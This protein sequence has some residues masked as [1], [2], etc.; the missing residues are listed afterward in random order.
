MSFCGALLAAALLIAPARP[1]SAQFGSS[2]SSVTSADIQRL[3]DAIY[4]ASRDVSQLRSRDQALASDLQAQLDDLRED[5]IY[6]KV[7]QRRSE[8]VSRSEV[9]D[10][11]D[12]IESI[13]ARARGESTGYS[14]SF[15]SST[16]D[17]SR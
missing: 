5:V 17:R 1:A 8:M 16:T 4:D 10:V 3:Q 12:R 6:L 13:R 9:N 11:R 2:Q 7:K 14:P 15:P